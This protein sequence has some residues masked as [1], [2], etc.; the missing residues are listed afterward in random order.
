MRNEKRIAGYIILLVTIIFTFVGCK[1][2]EEQ[3]TYKIIDTGMWTGDGGG[4]YKWLDNERVLF[5]SNETLLPQTGPS[6]MTVWNTVTGKVDFYQPWQSSICVDDGKIVFAV[7]DA[8]TKKITYYKGPVENPKEYPPPKP[9]MF[10]SRNYRCEWID[11]DRREGQNNYLYPY[12]IKM[13]G[14]NYLEVNKKEMSQPGI[15][16]EQF[17]FYDKDGGIPYDLPTAGFLP[18]YIQWRNAYLISPHQ[19]TPHKPI[20]LYW[21]ERDGQINL[22]PMP[23]DL[24]FPMKGGIG[25]LPTPNGMFI[26]YNGGDLIKDR[27]GYYFSKGKL[28]KLFH[29]GGHN[30][31]LSPNGC[32]AIFDHVE[33]QRDYFSMGKKHR[34]LRLIDFCAQGIL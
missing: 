12:R 6:R 17:T 27:G 2:N 10:M 31:E 30:V 5:P 3:K 33:N 7:T 32:K 25:F 4:R 16:D 24:P 23:S 15:C 21:L 34:T 13:R 1:N 19:Y 20:K 26:H 28:E 11:K 18:K 9:N 8:Q 22:I 29:G 14:D